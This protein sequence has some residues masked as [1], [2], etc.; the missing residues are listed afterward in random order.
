MLIV[1]IYELLHLTTTLFQ[2]LP[3]IAGHPF[4]L[5]TWLRDYCRQIEA[6]VVSSSRGKFHQTTCKP[7]VGSQ[8]F[9]RGVD[10][11]NNPGMDYSIIPRACER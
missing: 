11:H 6:E 8:Y 7:F 10:P 1:F 5:R 9:S 4:M 3:H 2:F